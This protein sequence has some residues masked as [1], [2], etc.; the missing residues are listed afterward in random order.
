MRSR[1]LRFAF[2]VLVIPAVLLAEDKSCVEQVKEMTLGSL[3][4]VVPTYFSYGHETR[5]RE[6]QTLLQRASAHYQK[7]LAINPTVTL[8]ALSQTDWPA[9]LDKPYGLPTMRSGPCRRGK[10][11]AAMPPQYLAILA[12]TSDGPIY[13]DWLKLEAKLSAHTKRKLKKEK[14]TFSAGG[15]VLLDFV[16]LHELGHAYA[17]AMGINPL[18]SFF[19]EFMGNYIAWSFLDA[20]PGR[21][22]EKTILVLRANVEGITP[23][24]SSLDRFE[25]FRSSEDPPTEAWYNSAFTIK[26]AEVYERRGVGFLREVAKAFQ[27]EEYGRITNEEILRRLE[28]I[29]PGFIAWAAKPGAGN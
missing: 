20:A 3:P 6:L 12:V 25:T 22:G 11:G 7:T 5:A 29:D 17:Q 9:V 18:S 19:A 8:A 1:L 2:I 13:Q 10:G 24:H 27:G 16:A 21:L 28:K 23:I 14:L 4:G 15:K 26:A